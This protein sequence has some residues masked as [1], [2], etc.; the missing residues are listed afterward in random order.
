MEKKVK[1]DYVG[2]KGSKEVQECMSQVQQRRKYENLRK[3]S[4][5]NLAEVRKLLRVGS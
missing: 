5:E 2:K 1:F 3:K 4:N